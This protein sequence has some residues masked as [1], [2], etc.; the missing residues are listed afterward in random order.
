[1]ENPRSAAMAAAVSLRPPSAHERERTVKMLARSLIREFVRT[2]YEPKQVIA[3][4]SELLELVTVGLRDKQP[5]RTADPALQGDSS[6]VE[7]AGEP[8]GGSSE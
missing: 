4:A 3:L 5:H 8:S 2:G 6:R 7:S 1:M